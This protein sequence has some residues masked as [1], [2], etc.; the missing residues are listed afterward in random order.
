I[1]LIA[2]LDDLEDP[3]FLFCR[4]TPHMPSPLPAIVH[5]SIRGGKNYCASFFSYIPHPWPGCR[6]R[7]RRLSDCKAAFFAV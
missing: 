5:K 4:N 6:L 1:L 7:G 3:F 2:D